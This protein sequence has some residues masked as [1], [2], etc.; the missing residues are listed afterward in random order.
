MNYS[1]I[2]L[3]REQAQRDIY[4][5]DEAIRQ[6]AQLIAGRLKSSRVQGSVLEELKRELRDYNM[7]TYSWKN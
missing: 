1:D 4:R 6:A 7:K 2:R 3:A 5:A